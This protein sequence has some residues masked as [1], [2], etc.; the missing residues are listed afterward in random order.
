M[1]GELF[2][3]ERGHVSP[4]QCEELTH[5]RR[6]RKELVLPPAATERPA[7]L[8]CLLRRWPHYNDPLH[9]A[10]NGWPFHVEA[11]EGYPFLRWVKVQV[12]NGGGVLR[13]GVNRVELWTDSRH[14][15]S[16]TVALEGGHA[17]PRSFLSTDG[18]AS[19]QNER[20]GAC[21][22]QRGE[23][24]VRLRCDLPPASAPPPPP[25]PHVPFVWEQPDHP[26]LAELRELIS[27]AIRQ[28]AAVDSWQA[29]RELAS[30]VSR[31]WPYTNVTDADRYTPWDPW[32]ILAGH[33]RRAFRMCVHYGI[34]FTCASLALGIPCRCV[35]TSDSFT[36][37]AGHFICEVWDERFNQW[38]AVD[39]NLDAVFI[40]E[41]GRP[42][43]AHELHGRGDQLASAARLGPG[44]A[45]HE[46]R[47]GAFLHGQVLTGKCF[48][49]TGVW[50]RNDFISR[51][52]QTPPAHGQEAYC[53]TE[54]VWRAG[55]AADEETGMFP[56]VMD[57]AWFAQ[58]PPPQWLRQPA[59]KPG[60]QDV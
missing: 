51:P 1:R 41:T 53:E 25:S 50:K 4:S 34:V 19:W 8:Y 38:S 10:I 40:D 46:R 16:W 43:A 13:A 27:P 24:V 32:T 33:D 15:N 49:L 3:S 17:S 23:Y 48:R 60:A 7:D 14:Q 2:L 30:W 37:K 45:Y 26:R 59:R 54:I 52:D 39:P 9:G 42:L 56:Y 28:R 35:V 55:A 29:A 31:A 22:V 44:A 6:A 21:H 58:P 57:E 36:G 11:T 18:G 5:Y 47:L 20:M 12:P